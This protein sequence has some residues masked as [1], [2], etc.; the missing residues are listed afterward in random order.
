MR[1]RI[2][3]KSW[4]KSEA[5]WIILFKLDDFVKNNPDRLPDLQSL[6]VQGGWADQYQG[7]VERLIPKLTSAKGLKDSG[8][9]IRFVAS[10][11]EVQEELNRLQFY[12]GQFSNFQGFAEM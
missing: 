3:T 8:K 5:Q 12:H 11:D 7:I 10:S 2:V 4:T 6:L 1:T 9:K